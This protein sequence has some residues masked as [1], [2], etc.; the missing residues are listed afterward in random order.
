MAWACGGDDTAGGTGG[1][2]GNTADTDSSA[3]GQGATSGSS[4]ASDAGGHSGGGIDASSGGQGASGG[5]SGSGGDA[6]ACLPAYGTFKAGNWPSGCWRPHSDASPFNQRIP[7][8]PK[9]VANS[10]AMV[11]RMLR[12]APQ[13]SMGFSWNLTATSD[14]GFPTY[15]PESTDPVLTVHCTKISCQP[16]FEGAQIRIPAKALPSLD[17]DG[18]MIVIDQSTNLEYDM[19]QA[20]MPG[21]S[22]GTVNC[23][24]GAATRID[25]DGVVGGGVAAGWGAM[26]GVIRAQELQAGV[27]NHALSIVLRCGKQ[28]AHVCP[29]RTDTDTTCVGLGDTDDDTPPMG[30]RFQW[31]MSDDPIA[32]LQVPDWKKSIFTAMAHFGMYY[33][34]NGGSPNWG[35]TTESTVMY[36]SLGFPDPLSAFMQAAGV[37]KDPNGMYYIDLTAGVDWATYPRVIDP[38][39]SQ[40]TC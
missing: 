12:D 28:N 3:G 21:T 36:L 26:A 6:G 23:S 30:T 31:A 18:H 40:G 7:A 37:K 16:S 29:A 13:A 1:S 25:G 35:V 39:V 11:A 38:C 20:K 24:V 2:G 22:G 27:I 14:W 15:F 9:L 34:D 8:N 32:A 10:A 5:S 19:W 4:G 17:V 33:R